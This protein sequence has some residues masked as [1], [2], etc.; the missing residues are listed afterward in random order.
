MSTGS[1]HIDRRRQNGVTLSRQNNGMPRR[2]GRGMTRPN[3][4]RARTRSLQ[5][6]GSARRPPSAKST[7]YRHAQQVP[8]IHIQP[9]QFQ[10]QAQYCG[11]VRKFHRFS[12][13]TYQSLSVTSGYIIH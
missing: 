5:H 6:S 1:Y 9:H 8:K 3:G 2:N 12:V 4:T 13:S 11:H 10:T 7:T